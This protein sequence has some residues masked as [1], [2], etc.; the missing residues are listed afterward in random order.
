MRELQNC[1]ERAVILAEG[2]GIHQRHFN[3]SFKQGPVASAAGTPWDQI[4][5]SGTMAEALHRVSSEVERRKI[6][7]A[8]QQ[9]GGDKA[10]AAESLRLGYKVLLQ[11]IKEYGI[12]VPSP[13]S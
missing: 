5:L 7:T 3:L 4:D 11:K 8:L 12:Q 10:R 9:A 2:D 1:I 6:G 13:A